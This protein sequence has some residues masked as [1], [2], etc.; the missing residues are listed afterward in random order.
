[1]F[2][3]SILI[4]TK[5]IKL[6]GISAAVYDIYFSL[7]SSMGINFTLLIYT[8]MIE[9]FFVYMKTTPFKIPLWLEAIEDFI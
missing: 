9:S 5:A 7:F 6:F 4:F 8:L 1:M 3:F 2:H